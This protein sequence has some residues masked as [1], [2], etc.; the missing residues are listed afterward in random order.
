MRSTMNEFLLSPD[1]LPRHRE[2]SK[3]GCW[4]SHVKAYLLRSESILGLPL[5]R[6]ELRHMTL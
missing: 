5:L 3:S 6:G 1:H 2:A 4:E